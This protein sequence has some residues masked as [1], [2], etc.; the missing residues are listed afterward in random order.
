MDKKLKDAESETKGYKDK[1]KDLLI[2]IEDLEYENRSLSTKQVGA[3]PTTQQN[4]SV[5]SSDTISQDALT[6]ARKQIEELENT[7]SELRT[8]IGKLEARKVEL[9]QKI[10]TLEPIKIATYQ[11]VLDRGLVQWE[12]IFTLIP[13]NDEDAKQQAKNALNELIVAA[14]KDPDY[15]EGVYT[16]GPNFE[17][18]EHG[19]QRLKSP[20]LSTNAGSFSDK[21]KGRKILVFDQNNKNVKLD[22]N[23]WTV[24][25]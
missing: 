15:L 1:I 5:T 7:N 9:D 24:V 17:W 12:N 6:E 2:E 22:L 21:L 18:I 4:Q 10:D 16:I 14:L 11:F 19:G 13:R 8:E 3:P 23:D 20:I 25:Q